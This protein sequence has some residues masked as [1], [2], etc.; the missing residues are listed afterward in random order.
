[1]RRIYPIYRADTTA[2]AVERRAVER[3]IARLKKSREVRIC[4]VGVGKAVDNGDRAGGVDAIDGSVAVRSAQ[5]SRAIEQSIAPLNDTGCWICA[6]A[7]RERVQRRHRP[8]GVRA[9][10]GSITKASGGGGSVKETVVG[11]H[12]A[13]VGIRAIAVRKGVQ[14]FECW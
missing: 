11:L 2:P 4:A 14:R 12:E 7:G 6:I 10:H 3:F 9:I 8:I 5:I 1:G 13:A